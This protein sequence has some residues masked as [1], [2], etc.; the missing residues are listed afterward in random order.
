MHCPRASC[1]Y[2]EW[3]PHPHFQCIEKL[4]SQNADMKKKPNAI[5]LPYCPH[6]VVLQVIRFLNVV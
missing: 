5:L 4:S 2:A 3:P 6:S 1:F